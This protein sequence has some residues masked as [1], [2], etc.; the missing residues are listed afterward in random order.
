FGSS[1]GN[2][3]GGT[4]GDGQ[5]FGTTDATGKPCVNLCLQVPQCPNGGTTS[6]SGSVYDPAGEVPP[7][8]GVAH[9]PNAPLDS[10]PSGA[11]CDKCGTVS[12][13]PVTSTLTDSSGSFK[14]AGVPVV[15]NLPLVFQVGKWRRAITLPDSFAVKPCEDNALTTAGLK[16]LT[17][18]PKNQG[19]GN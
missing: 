18:L 13:S 14:L 11:N 12:G 7:Y 3:D 10:V 5:D 8:N 2:G 1:G 4:S 9:V 16:D 17:R 19:E 15:K 6:L